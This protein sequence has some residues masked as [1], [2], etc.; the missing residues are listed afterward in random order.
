MW[1]LVYNGTEKALGDWG[2][3]ADFAIELLN[4][5][6]DSVTMRSTEALDAGPAQFAWGAP[7][8]LWRDRA[9]SGSP[10]TYTGGTVFFRGYVG[11][12]KRLNVQG[13]QN[14]QYSI[15]GP[16]WLLERLEFMQGRSVF[17]GW[18]TPGLPSSGATLKTIN[19]PEVFLGEKADETWQTNGQ[20]IV[21]VLNWVNEC[22][23]PT[24]QGATTGRDNTRD[25]IQIG[26]IDPN[27]NFPKTRAANIFCA[28]ALVNVLRW[29]PD[30]VCWFDYT[31][32]PPTFNA[33]SLAN[34]T[35]VSAAIT[36][37]QERQIEL[38]PRHERQLAGVVIEYKRTNVFNGFA[39]PQFYYDIYPPGITDY[40]PNCSRHFVEL[41]GSHVSR[42]DVAVQVVPVALAVSATP[43]DR[44][45]WWL[46]ADNTLSDPNI[47]PASIEVDVA[48]VTDSSGNPVDLTAYPNTLVKGQLSSWMGVQWTDATVTANVSF[49]RYADT[50][51]NQ[52]NATVQ[53][54]QVSQRVTLTNAVS[55]TYRTVT[56]FDPGE[57]VPTGVAQAL[58][59]SLAT[60]QYSGSVAFVA[61]Q[62]QSGIGVGN[63]LT[64]AGPANTYPNLLVQ[65]IRAVPHLGLL[66][67]SYAPSARLDAPELIELARCCRWRTIYNMP[68]G[69]STGQA[70]GC[71]DVGLGSATAKENTQHGLGN[72]A[73]QAVTYDQGTTGGNPNG[74]TQIAKDARNELISILRLNAAGGVVGADGAGNP[75]GQIR[76]KLSDA[77]G[78]TLRIGRV[79][80]TDAQTGTAKC[81]WMLRAPGIPD[82]PAFGADGTDD[83]WLGGGGG[84]EAPAEMTLQSVQGDYVTAW[85][86]PAPVTS[87]TSSGTT[88]TVT[89]AAPHGLAT[90]AVLH[91]KI[92]GATPSAYNGT[93][94]VT[95]TG[96]STFTYV[97][98][99]GTSSPATGAMTYQADVYVAKNWKLRRSR[100]SETGADGTVYSLLFSG[101]TGGPAAGPDANNVLRLKTGTSGPGS[102]LVETEAVAP[103]WLVGD[104]FYAL[105]AA[106]GLNDA[107]GNPIN[108]IIAGES[109]NWTAVA[110]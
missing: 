29:S 1:T 21:E 14:I 59:T 92:V 32:S 105:P 79:H 2:L 97:V 83:V 88:A 72:Y 40:M 25:A 11:D 5:G 23:N 35:A 37:G 45:S 89:T 69:R 9:G 60:L 41:D 38:A 106:T 10:V 95:V 54:R 75:I 33:R 53:S 100:T 24:K 82:P 47:D 43:S 84:T 39:W 6:R 90:G 7:V 56:F 18:A 49:C 68:S 57:A 16:W 107:N 71:N 13:R 30:V 103:E 87:I 70:A 93:F 110:S 27:V 4:K 81:C 61:G 31:T 26:T 8:T 109:R 65:A 66:S 80:Y 55:Q 104:V 63:T 85:F 34:L 78:Q 76:E 101:D 99:S 86:A 62:V 22:Y 12:T 67:V 52:P 17:N 28:E 20:Q 46:A 77:E 3:C 48:A 102:G 96:P 74:V 42:T 108:L 98:P 58:Y 36:A 15:Y 91:A 73:L 94:S 64:L 51:H 19:T 50:A 44:L